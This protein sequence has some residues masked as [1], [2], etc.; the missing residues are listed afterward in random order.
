MFCHQIL[1]IK[2]IYD[3]RVSSEQIRL[4]LVNTKYTNIKIIGSYRKEL[5]ISLNF[6]FMENVFYIIIIYR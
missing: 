1:Y 3:K 4:A 5:V 6:V 2:K